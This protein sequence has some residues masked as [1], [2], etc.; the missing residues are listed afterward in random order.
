MNLKQTK[1]KLT[2]LGVTFDPKAKLEDLTALLKEN[3]PNEQADTEGKTFVWLK[4]RAYIDEKTRLEA[5]VYIVE[6][7]LVTSRMKVAG[8]DVIEMYP[9]DEVPVE[10]LNKTAKLAGI[11]TDSMKTDDIKAKVFNVVAH[12]EFKL[13]K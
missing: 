11:K 4:V 2:E 3:T 13:L 1:E 6:D 5:G 10:V 7:S 12:K 9:I 8:T